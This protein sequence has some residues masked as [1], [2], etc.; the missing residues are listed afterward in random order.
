VNLL[1]AVSNDTNDKIRAICLDLAIVSKD[2]TAEEQARAV[3]G[4]FGELA[5]LLQD[6]RD[7]TLELFPNQPELLDAIPDPSSIDPLKML[8]IQIMHDTIVTLQGRWVTCCRILSL[9][10][11]RKRASQTQLSLLF[12]KTMATIII[13]VAGGDRQD[14]S[15]EGSLALWCRA[16]LVWFS[17]KLGSKISDGGSQIPSAVGTISLATNSHID[18][19]NRNQPLSFFHMDPTNSIVWT[20]KSFIGL[21]RSCGVGFLQ[22]LGHKSVMDPSCRHNF[23]TTVSKSI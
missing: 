9:T 7:T 8:R 13:Q 23:L 20:R 19:T 18:I 2:S 21:M 14:A 10:L 12:F 11:L 16:G 1:I 5:T 17:A 3:I 15:L 4:V 22:N 6:W